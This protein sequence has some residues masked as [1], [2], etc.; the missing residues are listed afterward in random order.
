MT[1]TALVPM[2]RQ[3]KNPQHQLHCYPGEQL[4]T[5]A[6]LKKTKMHNISQCQQQAHAVFKYSVRMSP[7]E[8]RWGKPDETT[9]N[10]QGLDPE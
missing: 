1:S 7:H 8:E 5:A 4:R 10:S 6:G 2:N 3:G 9:Q